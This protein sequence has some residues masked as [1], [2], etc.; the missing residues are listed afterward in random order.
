MSYDHGLAERISA[1]INSEEGLAQQEMFGGI[2]FL[3]HGN[4]VCGVIGEELIARVGPEAAERL[5]SESGVRVFDMTGR[6][7]RGWVMVEARLLETG[8]ELAAWIDRALD[9]TRSMPPKARKDRK[10]G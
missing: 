5:L 6:P 4:M 1:H 3:L 8:P 7:M 9:F 2:S 10:V